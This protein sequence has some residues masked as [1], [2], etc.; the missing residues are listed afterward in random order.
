MLFRNLDPIK[1]V[2]L[3]ALE[4]Q[5]IRHA[6]DDA[7]RQAVSTVVTSLKKKKNVFMKKNKDWA[8]DKKLTKEVEQFDLLMDGLSKLRGTSAEELAKQVAIRKKAA[9]KEV[10]KY[11]KIVKE[12]KKRAAK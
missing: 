11:A 3:S 6:M 10:K 8:R 4:R 5:L 2:D 7:H 9:Q 12:Q 1:A